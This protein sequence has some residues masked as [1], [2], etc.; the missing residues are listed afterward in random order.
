MVRKDLVGRAGRR[1]QLNNKKSG[2]QIHAAI[3]HLFDFGDGSE[4]AE[5]D[6][7]FNSIDSGDWVVELV[8]CGEIGSISIGSVFLSCHNAKQIH[9]L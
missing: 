1:T 3:S 2:G 4:L 7:F 6:A 9:E 5:F 8:P